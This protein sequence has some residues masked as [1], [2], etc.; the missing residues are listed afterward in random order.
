MPVEDHE[1][2]EKTRTTTTKPRWCTDR[3]DFG[4]GYFAPDREYF[5]DGRFRQI[6][7]WIPHTM[8]KTCR[9]DLAESDSQCATCSRKHEGAEYTR[10]ITG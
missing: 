9:Y 7:V 5:P 6:N 4:T 3:P 2:H 8:S 10:R 1:V